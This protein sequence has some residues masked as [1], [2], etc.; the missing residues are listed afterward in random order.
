M[1]KIRRDDNMSHTWM[2]VKNILSELWLQASLN[3]CWYPF[4]LLAG[5]RGT[6][7]AACFAHARTQHIKILD[8]WKFTYLHR[9]GKMKLGDPYFFFQEVDWNRT[10]TERKP[11]LAGHLLLDGEAVWEDWKE[12]SWSNMFTRFFFFPFIFTKPF[13]QD[14]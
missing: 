7:R 12:R 14:N 5:Q 1:S 9:G 11:K 4:L 6:L 8:I 10:K 13:R 3:I 2:V